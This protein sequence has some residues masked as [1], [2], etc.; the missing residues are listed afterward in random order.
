MK[1]VSVQKL[2]GIGSEERKPVVQG[3]RR[4]RDL[5]LR[6]RIQKGGGGWRCRRA[7]WSGP[8]AALSPSQSQSKEMVSRQWSGRLHLC[9][10]CDHL[11]TP[12]LPLIKIVSTD[13]ASPCK[14]ENKWGE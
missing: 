10:C 12:T 7:V 8:M 3:D 4:L 1:A 13:S 5:A 11:P 9:S 2:K 14:V 6:G